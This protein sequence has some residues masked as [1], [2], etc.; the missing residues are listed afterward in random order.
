MFWDPVGNITYEYPYMK[1]FHC[2]MLPA[3]VPCLKTQNQVERC[4]PYMM[5]L[6]TLH[7]GTALWFARLSAWLKK[8]FIARKAIYSS[9]S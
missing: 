5:L 8:E 3:N 1:N 4:A 7:T 6:S 2:L 9:D